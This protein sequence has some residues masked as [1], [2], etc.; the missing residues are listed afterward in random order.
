[1][2][3]Q[4]LNLV[5]TADTLVAATP[6]QIVPAKFNRR[7][8]TVQNT[9]TGSMRFGFGSAEAASAGLALDA[10]S[11]ALGQGGSYH[12]GDIVSTSAI[13]AVSA[14]GTTVSVLE[15]LD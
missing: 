12:F 7:G 4:Q 6:K 9:G 1:M 14:A 2:T 13:W 15:M 8:L 5:S 3:T 10:A 11:G